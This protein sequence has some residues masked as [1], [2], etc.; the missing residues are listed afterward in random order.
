MQILR[1][2]PVV[3]ARMV[4]DIVAN[5]AATGFDSR[6]PPQFAPADG[7]VDG[8][9]SRRR[10]FKS[11]SGRQ[12]SLADRTGAQPPKPRYVSSNLTEGASPRASNTIG[13]CTRLKSAIGVG[14][15]PTWPT[16]HVRRW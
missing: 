8:L 3:R 6:R 4:R 9:L 14:S 13:R 15:S 16:N 1:Q 10:W 2:L 11:N 7:S 12:L 5:D